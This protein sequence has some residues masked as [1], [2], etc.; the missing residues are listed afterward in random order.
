MSSIEKRE[1]W[2]LLLLK[3]LVGV[4]CGE[5]GLEFIIQFI[6]T[7]LGEEDGGDQPPATAVHQ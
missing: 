5:H 1:Q 6:I 7:P 3:R 2:F 4:R